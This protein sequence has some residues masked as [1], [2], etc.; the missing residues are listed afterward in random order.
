MPEWGLQDANRWGWVNTLG[1]NSHASANTKST[2]QEMIATSPFAAAGIRVTL[3][4][5]GGVRDH[6]VDIAVGAAGSEQVIAANL[7]ASGAT[8]YAQY[9]YFLPVPIPAGTRIASRHQAS[10]GSSGLTVHIQ[11]VASAFQGTAL[12]RVAT[13][14]VNT[15]D[16]GATQ[17]DPG[18]SAGTK[19]AWSQIVA[20]TAFEVKQAVLAFGNQVNSARTSCTWDVDLGI[21]GAGSEQILIENILNEMHATSDLFT[22]TTAEFPLAIPSGSRLAVRAKC[23]IT[24]AT[25][26]VF[27]AALYGIG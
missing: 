23:T 7:L 13:W 11:L 17:V 10:T 1:Y 26:R 19:G 22:L 24:D 8:A 18:G 2:W 6:L 15:G 20:A 27:D 4:A 3:S 21:G 25:D 16:S 12:G 5:W 14:G 9:S